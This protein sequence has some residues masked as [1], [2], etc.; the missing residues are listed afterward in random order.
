[1]SKI[2]SEKIG[3]DFDYGLIVLTAVFLVAGI[4]SKVWQ[5]QAALATLAV[6]GLIPVAKSA[7][8]SIKEKR[9]SV[10]LLAA[11]ALIFSLLAKEWYSAAFITLMLSFARLFDSITQARAKKTIE[12]LMKYRVERVTLKIGDSIKEVSIDEVRR[13]DQVVV[14]A[15]DRVPVDGVVVSGEAFLDEATLTGESELVQKKAG[16]KVF[17]STMSDSGSLIVKTLEIGEDTTLSKMIALVQEASRDKSPAERSADRFAE[18]Y[19]S[20]SLLAAIIMYF[21]GLGMREIL[22]VLLVVCADDIAVAVPLSF[23]VGISSL[24]KRGVIVKGSTAME[25]LSKMRYLFTDKT[26]TLTRGKPKITEIK[27][28]GNYDQ[29]DVLRELACGAMESRHAVSKAISEYASFKGQKNHL[30]DET[31]EIAGQGVVYR[32][33]QKHLLMGRLSFLE[34]KNTKIP[35]EARQEIAKQK[36]AGRGVVC[37]AVDG[38]LVGM[39]AYRDELRFGAKNVVADVRSMGVREWHMLTGDNEK[40][41]AMVAKELGIGH[42]HANMT[43]EGK[44]EFIRLFKAKHAK[45]EDGLVGFVGDG[46]NDAASLALA[47]VSIAMGGIGADAAIEASDI[48]I[49]KDKLSGIKE[50]MKVSRKTMSIMKGN[51]W[52][53]GITNVIGLALVVAGFIG[54]AGAATY[55][56]LTDF[57]PIGNAFRAGRK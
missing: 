2:D 6:V 36:D 30:P 51:Y 44:V 54:P 18:W 53:W 4:W 38:V 12:S 26:G 45:K 29:N 14:N 46:V 34:N 15:G 17:S 40:V 11:I 22:A 47:D 19:I 39:A 57:I 10:D 37:L 23:T 3:I 42:F 43:P 55:N 16:D 28:Y 5:I 52:I 49:M 25:Q 50:A 35:E 27:A 20:L 1:M 7:F 21:L 31:E 32:L 56:F 33:D 8:D 48:T 9:I 41:A 24:A 13:G